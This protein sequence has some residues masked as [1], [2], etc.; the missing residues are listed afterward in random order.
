MCWN[1]NRRSS[2]PP[3]KAPLLIDPRI[4]CPSPQGMGFFLRRPPRETSAV[5]PR[6]PVHRRPTRRDPTPPC[7]APS[8][9]KTKNPPPILGKPQLI[10]IFA[11]HFESRANPR[12]RRN[13][14]TERCLSGRKGR[15]A[16]PLYELKLVSRVRIP[17][18]PQINIKWCSRRSREHFF[19]R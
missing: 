4:R 16:K 1:F 15:F 9:L 13:G 11:S 12:F 6:T 18:S 8:A 5:S 19:G 14:C 3:C 10:F 17:P 7:K 2:S